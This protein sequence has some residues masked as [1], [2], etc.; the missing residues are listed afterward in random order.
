MKLLLEFIEPDPN[1]QGYSEEHIAALPV[2]SANLM[3]CDETSSRY[4]LLEEISVRKFDW[5]FHHKP[6]GPSVRRSWF[7]P[8][9]RFLDD[10]NVRGILIDLGAD[11]W[12]DIYAVYE[13]DHNQDSVIGIL[14]IASPFGM[15]DI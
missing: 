15:G 6:L 13:G 1:G 10:G 3:V 2:D 7:A 8:G 11:G 12:Y 14:V 9:A 5:T 4:V